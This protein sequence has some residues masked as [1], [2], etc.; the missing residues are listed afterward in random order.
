[1]TNPA[2]HAALLLLAAL[3]TGCSKQRDQ[4]AIRCSI[5]GPLTGEGS[6]YVFLADE[7]KQQLIW[8]GIAG[9]Q[10]V[11][12]RNWSAER[13]EGTLSNGLRQLSLTYDRAQL[14][15]TLADPTGG[16]PNVGKCSETGLTDNEETVLASEAQ[17]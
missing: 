14:S 9:P 3:A 8:N 12:I 1:M 15:M 2:T 17:S 11:S 6:D 4:F 13:V 16:E 7:P 5:S 10:P